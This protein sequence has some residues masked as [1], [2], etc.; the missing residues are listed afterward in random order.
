[1]NTAVSTLITSDQ[2]ENW[3]QSLADVITDPKELRQY[4]GL[5]SGPDPLGR[6]A[7]DQFPLRVPRGFAAR[8]EKGNWHDPLLRQVWPDSAEALNSPSLVS[9]PLQEASYNL[10]P[11]MLQKYRGRVLLTAAP[12]CAIHCRYCFRRNFD[13]YSNT[14]GRERWTETLDYIAHDQTISEVILSG[15]DP[16]AAADTY[17]GWMLTALDAIPHLSTLRIHTRLPVV[18]PSRITHGLRRIFRGLTKPLLI[19]IHC[20]HG[21]ELDRQAGSALD[22]LAGD[23]HLLLNQSVLLRGV[24]DCAATLMDLSRSLIAHRVLPYYLHLPDAIAGTGHFLVAE[25]EAVEL[26]EEMRASLPGYLVPRLVREEPGRP[27]KTPVP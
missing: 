14:P 9:D 23:G 7:L 6:D 1:M 26:M 3:Q 2:P 24:N 18:I 4:L 10:R 27:S 13:Y 11:G 19:V 21:N 15:G 12:H 20:N 5:G 22:K 8:M 16:L 25:N 17:L